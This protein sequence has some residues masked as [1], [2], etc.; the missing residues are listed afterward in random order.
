MS[1]VHLHTHSHYSLLDGLPK[2]PDLV[3][4]AKEHGSPALALTDHGVMYGA[5][6]FYQECKKQGV[7]PIIGLEAYVAPDKLTDKRAKAEDDYHHLTILAKDEE[8][9]KNLMHLSTV[10]HLEGYYYRPR[11]DKE[12]LRAHRRGLIALSGCLSGE[13]SKLIIR[14]QTQ[15]ARKVAQE[16]ID[17]FGKESII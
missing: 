12:L 5:L 10:A 2:I 3:A 9:Y 8:G 15:E 6:E 14:G 13:I 1:F 16:F 11:I 4:R 7:K 17:I